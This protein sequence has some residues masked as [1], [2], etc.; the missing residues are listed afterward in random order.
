MDKNKKQP[1]QEMKQELKIAEL[2]K[3]AKISLILDSYD[4]LFSDFDPRPYHERALSH[5]FLEECKRATRD[6]KDGSQTELSLAIPQYQ[7]NIADETTIKKRLKEH[8]TKHA[9]EKKKAIR[10]RRKEGA[11]WFFGGGLIS[12]LAAKIGMIDNNL[13][14]LFLVIFEPAGWFTIWTGLEMIANPKEKIPDSEFYRKMERM[15]IIFKGY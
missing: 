11:I 14:H 9:H 7:R 10:K 3:E 1:N 8:F 2:A 4:D 5:D 6:T 15:N 13:S 12:L